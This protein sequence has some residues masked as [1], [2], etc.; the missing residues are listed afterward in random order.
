MYDM[1]DDVII[2][3]LPAE[4]VNATESVE[5]GK[6]QTLDSTP[7]RKFFYGNNNDLTDTEIQDLN[8]IWGYFSQDSNGPGETLGKLRDLERSL[9]QAPPGV[10]RV[11]H[12]ASYVKLL[13]HEQDIQKEKSAYYG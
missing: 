8:M 4:T 3:D 5:S 12:L 13:A 9:A 2:T 1:N 6:E 11:Q 7:L 10:T